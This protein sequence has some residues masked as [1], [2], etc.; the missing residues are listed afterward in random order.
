MG[1]SAVPASHAKAEQRRILTTVSVKGRI[2]MGAGS[3]GHLILKSVPDVRSRTSKE[4]SFM[5]LIAAIEMDMVLSLSYVRP[6]SSVAIGLVE[7]DGL[8][9]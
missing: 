3:P 6:Q 1:K 4:A 9:I 8:W 7:K 5:R 2:T